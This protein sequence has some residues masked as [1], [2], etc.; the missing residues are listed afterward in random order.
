MAG[1]VHSSSSLVFYQHF[2]VHGID[3]ITCIILT[4]YVANYDSIR[5]RSVYTRTAVTPGGMQEIL[6]VRTVEVVERSRW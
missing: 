2:N 6:A 4:S 5:R 1:G 3:D